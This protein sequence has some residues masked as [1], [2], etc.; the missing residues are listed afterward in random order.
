MHEREFLLGNGK[1]RPGFPQRL[2]CHSRQFVLLHHGAEN[3]VNT[4]DRPLYVEQV[5]DGEF[6]VEAT[7]DFLRTGLTRDW[8]FD[9]IH[10]C[11]EK[12][13]PV[14]PV[15]QAAQNYYEIRY[16]SIER[17]AGNELPG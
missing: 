2:G 8:W 5:A 15:N 7:A 10:L 16:H 17:R 14:T 3:R 9:L 4:Q 12:N 1:S 11:R 13:M 6:G